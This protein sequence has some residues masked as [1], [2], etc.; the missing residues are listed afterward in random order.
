MCGMMITVLCVCVLQSFSHLQD[1]QKG[2]C[3]YLSKFLQLIN[4]DSIFFWPRIEASNLLMPLP[5]FTTEEDCRT[6]LRYKNSVLQE[7]CAWLCCT[8][9][10]HSLTCSIVLLHDKM[11]LHTLEMI[12]TLSVQHNL[13]PRQWMHYD[14]QML[15]LVWHWEVMAHHCSLDLFPH[16]YFLFNFVKAL[17]WGHQID[18]MNKTSDAINK[19]I[20]LLLCCL[21]T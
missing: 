9:L 5:H 19:T 17:L 2:G 4:H 14:R 11:N 15:L 13:I 21:N 16:D 3:Y 7:V 18:V 1:W 8:T 12:R 20:I 6:V 10:H